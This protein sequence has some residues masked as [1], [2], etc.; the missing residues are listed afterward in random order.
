MKLIFLG[1]LSLPLG[2]HASSV[3]AN[4]VDDAM[5]ALSE[6]ERDFYDRVKKSRDQSPDVINKIHRETVGEAIKNL[7]KEQAKASKK[8]LEN[9]SSNEATTTPAKV[10]TV[11]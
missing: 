6:A 2:L 1:I 8:A 9:A 7:R 4:G 10:E 5:G 3:S 11:T